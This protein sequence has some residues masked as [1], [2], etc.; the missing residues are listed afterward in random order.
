MSSKYPLYRHSR[1]KFV[2]SSQHEKR[3][4]PG[5]TFIIIISA[6]IKHGDLKFNF[7]EYKN[8]S[9]WPHLCHVCWYLRATRSQTWTD[10]AF[11]HVSL[12]GLFLAPHLRKQ[13]FYKHLFSIDI[14]TF[15][16]NT[17]YMCLC[18]CVCVCV[19]GGGGGGGVDVLLKMG[20]FKR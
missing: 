19:W 12:P 10:S 5:K 7:I 2:V 17:S 11:I 9:T 6:I 1:T 4:V 18:V 3:R 14:N 8:P 20:S 13:C 16:I 15:T